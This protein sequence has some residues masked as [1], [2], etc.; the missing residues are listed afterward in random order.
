MGRMESIH[1]LNV[2]L[3][4]PNMHGTF[5]KMEQC[6]PKRELTKEIIRCLIK[7]T[8]LCA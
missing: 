3:N 5:W 4:S 7:T 2:N 1:V 6:G 8:C